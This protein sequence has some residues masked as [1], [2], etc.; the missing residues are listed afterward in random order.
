MVKNSIECL[1]LYKANNKIFPNEIIFI[2]RSGGLTS[3]DAFLGDK[4]VS[5]L[6]MELKEHFEN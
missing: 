1:E 6:R 3:N 5:P 4:F 2:C